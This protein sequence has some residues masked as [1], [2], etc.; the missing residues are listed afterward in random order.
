M[1]VKCIRNLVLLNKYFSRKISFYASASRDEVS[2]PRY[3]VRQ[4]RFTLCC[5]WQMHPPMT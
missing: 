3:T 4:K 2:R 1:L 5:S